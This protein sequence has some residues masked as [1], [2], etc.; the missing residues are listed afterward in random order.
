MADISRGTSQT[1]LLGERYL[2]PD[3]YFD[4][5][6]PG[7]NEAMFVG[8][9][10]DNSRETSVLPIQDTRGV[11]DTQRFGTHTAAVCTCSFATA[12]CTLSPTTSS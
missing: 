11:Q 5:T 4:G 1:F 12:R 9:D 6:D 3:R 8:T 2:D 7:D 10:N